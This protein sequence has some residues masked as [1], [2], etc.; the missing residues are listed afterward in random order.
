LYHKLQLH[1]T[2]SLHNPTVDTLHAGSDSRGSTELTEISPEIPETPVITLEN[3]RLHSTHDTSSVETDNLQRIGP[4][5]SIV[6]ADDSE[7][8]SLEITESSEQSLAAITASVSSKDGLMMVDISK[9]T[10][11]KILDKRVECVWS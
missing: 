5:N 2:T 4:T 3:I 1:S 6:N 11:V 10:T 9:H 8:A 7:E